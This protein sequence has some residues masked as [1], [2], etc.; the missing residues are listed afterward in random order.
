MYKR[1]TIIPVLCLLIA[2]LA[3]NFPFSTQEVFQVFKHPEQTLTA[4][5]AVLPS[6]TVELP[7]EESGE[8]QPTGTSEPAETPL[9][10]TP[11]ISGLERTGQRVTA[12]YLVSAPT[13]DGNWQEWRNLTV[14]YPS[15][16]VVYGWGNWQN[17]DD[18]QASFILG[19]D[20]TYLYVAV[21]VEDDKYVQNSTAEYI[22]K[23]DSLE[24]QMDINLAADFYTDSLSSDDYQLGIAPGKGS[25]SGVKE[26]YLWYPESQMGSRTSAVT[27][28]SI[29]GDGEYRVEVKIPWSVFGISPHEGMRVGFALSVSDNDNAAMNVQQ[30]MVSNIITR[31]RGDPTTWG[32]L[33]LIK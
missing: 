16:Y 20:N 19:W 17:A 1:I 10:P 6:A 28:A 33:M 24:I 26:A 18:M 8:I 31:M 30:S 25:T 32:E 21:E 15:A 2:I 13:I 29:G 4:M 27:I 7:V 22:Y 3:C 14:V 11:T 23:G 9:I 12:K 5:F